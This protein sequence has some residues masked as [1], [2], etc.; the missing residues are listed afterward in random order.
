MEDP[1]PPLDTQRGI[2]VS[3]PGLEGPKSI[4]S[5]DNTSFGGDLTFGTCRSSSR[6]PQLPIEATVCWTPRGEVCGLLEGWSSTAQVPLRLAPRFLSARLTRPRLSFFGNPWIPYYSTP[7]Y[8]T[9]VHNILLE[10][11]PLLFFQDTWFEVGLKG[12]GHVD[13]K[14]ESTNQFIDGGG[15]FGPS[16]SE[17]IPTFHPNIPPP[18]L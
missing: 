13:P 3:K 5:F 11:T 16:K 4:A 6:L 1:D 7:Y 12:K 14:Y 10:S 8:S 18:P 2:G 15:G 9:P 17:L